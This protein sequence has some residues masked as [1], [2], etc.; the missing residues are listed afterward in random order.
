MIQYFLFDLSRSRINFRRCAHAFRLF[1]SCHGSLRG[2][3][4]SMEADASL[5]VRLRT[6]R[7]PVRLCQRSFFGC[8]L[9][10]CISRSNRASSRAAGNKER[11][12]NC[13]NANLIA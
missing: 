13:K 11:K 6:P 8:H 9:G 4:E 10:V 1:R 12:T 3:G 7:N 5:F 2:C